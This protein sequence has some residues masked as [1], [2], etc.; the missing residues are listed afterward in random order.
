MDRIEP[1]VARQV[2]LVGE[3]TEPDYVSMYLSEVGALQ[4]MQALVRVGVG[5]AAGV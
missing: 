1:D 3:L 4:V 2:G 5:I